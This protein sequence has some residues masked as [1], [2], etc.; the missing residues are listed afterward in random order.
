M[1]FTCKKYD[2]EI[3]FQK[4]RYEQLL[5]IY[6]NRIYSNLECECLTIIKKRKK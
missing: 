1:H 4:E 2:G 5:N 3:R 6:N